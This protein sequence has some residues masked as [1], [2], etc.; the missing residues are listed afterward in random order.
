MNV[1][2]YIFICP[3]QPCTGKQL[4]FKFL[5]RLFLIVFQ[6]KKLK[7]LKENK[8]TCEATLHKIIFN[9]NNNKIFSTCFNL[10]IHRTSK[11]LSV[12]KTK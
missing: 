7:S 6:G 2:Y 11:N 9:N 1:S 4:L 12:D 5:I 10:I 8:C 3:A